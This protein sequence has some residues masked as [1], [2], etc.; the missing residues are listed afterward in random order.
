[1]PFL[2][3]NT[4]ILEAQIDEFLDAISQSAIVYKQAINN[5]LTGDMEKFEERMTA[6]DGLESKAD[7][8]R[9]NVENQLYGQSLIPEHRG[10]VLALLESMDNVIDT[11]KQTVNQFSVESP[12][13]PEELNDEYSELAEIAANAAEA[14]VSATRAFFSDI[15][16]VKDHLH[17]VY[18]YEKEADKVGDKLKRHVFSL[19][20]ELSRKIHLRYFAL[21]VDNLADRSEEV[22][23]RL[24]IYSIKREI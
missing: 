21:H 13:I 12:D 9:R 18:F 1:M 2:F 22:A 23:D 7:K 17:K 8:I 11:A 4:K 14:I 20:I 19:D 3:K 16:A 24:S 10:D 15:A 5:Y 6:I